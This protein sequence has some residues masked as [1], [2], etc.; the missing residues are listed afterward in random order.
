[1]IYQEQKAIDSNWCKLMMSGL[2]ADPLLVTKYALKDKRTVEKIRVVGSSIVRAFTRGIYEAED[3]VIEMHALAFYTK[4]LPRLGATVQNAQIVGAVGK[5]FELS[6]Y[7]A[8]PD[9]GPFGA[10]GVTNLAKGC[11][12]I[13]FESS[14]E[15]TEKAT[16]VMVTISIKEIVWGQSGLGGGI[17]LA[18]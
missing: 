14:T 8:D 2:S 10:G 3:T 12:V 5:V 6:E 17:S 13:G 7:V 1:M 11:E 4:F 16:V 15:N 9:K 18:R